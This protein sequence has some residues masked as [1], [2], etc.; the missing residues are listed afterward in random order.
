MGCNVRTSVWSQRTPEGRNRS[1]DKGNEINICPIR[2]GGPYHAVC[3]DALIHV[4]ATAQS[5]LLAVSIWELWSCGTAERASVV[6]L[7]PPQQRWLI[8]SALGPGCMKTLEAIIRA[9][10]EN[11]ECGLGDPLVRQRLPVRTNPA[12]ERSE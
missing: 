11:R 9:Q 10:Q 1:G 7:S 5:P 12:P 2:M 3:K 6:G 8:M 4:T